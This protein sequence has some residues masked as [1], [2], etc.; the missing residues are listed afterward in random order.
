MPKTRAVPREGEW[1]PSSVLIRVDLPAP[2]GPSRPMALPRSSP[3]SPS[4]TTRPPSRTSNRSRSI[5]PMSLSYACGPASCS[6]ESSIAPR[7][8]KSNPNSRLSL[9]TSMRYPLPNA[10]MA[11]GRESAA[12]LR[13]ASAD[14]PLNCDS[15]GVEHRAQVLVRHRGVI[16]VLVLGK[17]RPECRRAAQ[18][19]AAGVG[20]QRIHQQARG[21]ARRSCTRRRTCSSPP[22]SRR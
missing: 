22:L 1:K 7:V 3:V 18:R 19:V 17:Q 14:S 5:T 9:A 6:R 8:R 2:L 4:R 15:S 10:Q 12:S 13:M 16:L 11:V 20:L 21:W